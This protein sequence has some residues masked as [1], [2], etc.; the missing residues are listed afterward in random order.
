MGVL[1]DKV[2]EP[3]EYMSDLSPIW[4]ILGVVAFVAAITAVLIVL[5]KKKKGGK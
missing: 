1:W 2:T 5:L 3:F 4:W